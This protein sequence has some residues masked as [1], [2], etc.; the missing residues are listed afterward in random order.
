MEMLKTLAYQHGIGNVDDVFNLVLEREASSCTI[1]APGIA[2]PHARLDSIDNLLIS[3]A[4]SEKGIDFNH[5]EHGSAKLVVLLLVPKSTPAAYLQ[6]MS[7]IAKIFYNTDA[8]KTVC[9]LKNSDEIWRFFDRGGALLPDHVCAGDIMNQ[10]LIT[11]QEDDT[12]E[13]AIDTFVKYN[14]TDLPVVDKDGELTGVVSTYELLRVCLP[15]YILWMDDLSPFINFEPFADILRNESKTW[16]SDIM[17]TEYPSISEEAPAVQVAREI[18]VS[19][20]R[21]VFVTR[22]K[23]LVG[24]ITLQT[25]INKVLRD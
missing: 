2:I 3:I 23:K 1:L 20:A 8:Q 14:L 10:E 22:G 18:T 17:S 4:T 21:Q 24:E 19:G 12:L 13:H 11:L 25:F 16:L 6:A 9:E 15:E 5:P 7:S